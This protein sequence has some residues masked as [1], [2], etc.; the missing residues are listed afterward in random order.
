MTITY[1]MV[2]N[3]GFTFHLYQIWTLYENLLLSKIHMVATFSEPFLLITKCGL[4]LIYRLQFLEVKF[5][6]IVL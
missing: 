5:S 2:K 1:W 6:S 3:I 4:S